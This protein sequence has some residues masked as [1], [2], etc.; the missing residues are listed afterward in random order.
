MRSG[1]GLWAAIAATAAVGWASSVQAEAQGERL[2]ERVVRPALARHCYECHSA[3]ADE[4]KGGLRLDRPQ[5]L[6]RGGDSGKPA[7]VPGKPG[8]SRLI[9]AIRYQHDDLQMPPEEKLPADV[10]ADIEKWVRM[11]APDPR[12]KQQ[13]DG[14]ETESSD[15]SDT[16]AY[17][18]PTLPKVPEVDHEGWARTPIDR[19]ILARLEE[20]GLSPVRDAT[21][22]ALIR[23]ASFDLLGLPPTRDAVERFL[24]DDRPGAFERAVDRMLASPAF[25]ERWGRHWLDVARYAESTGKEWNWAFPHAWRYRD[26][27][28]DAF[29]EDKPYDQ[30]I[31]EQL[32]GDLLPADSDAE[33]SEQRTA[34]GFLAIGPKSVSIG[35]NGKFRMQVADEQIRATSRAFLGLTVGCARCHDHKFDPVTME[36]YYGLAGMFLSTKTLFGTTSKGYK[37]QNNNQARGLVPIG[38]NADERQKAV[39]SHEKKL[40]K[41]GKQLKKKKKALKKAKKKLKKLEDAKQSAGK[42]DKSKKKAK[43]AERARKRVEKLRQK[44]GSLK[45]Q[46]KSLKNNPPKEPKYTMGVRDRGDPGDTKLRKNGVF[47][48]RGKKVA[49]GFPAELTGE[50]PPEVP[51]DRSGRRALAE[52][53]TQPR[54]PVTARV[55]VN[56][57]WHYLFGRGLV[58]TVDN[59]GVLGRKPTHPKLLDYLAV[60][61]AR[62]GWSIKRLIRRIMV[63]RVYRMSTAYQEAGGSADP[64]NRLLWRMRP[65]RLDAESLRD[66][67]LAASGALD[68]R[69]VE[70]SPAVQSLPNGWI[71]KEIHKKKFEKR[72]PERRRSV[73][74]PILRGRVPQVLATFDFPR[75]SLVQGNREVTTVPSQA[76]FMMNSPFVIEQSQ[77]MADR[78][79]RMAPG[80]A[81]KRVSLAYELALVRKPR[82]EER[83]RAVKYVEEISKTLAGKFEDERKRR[84]KAWASFCQTLFASAEFRYLI[85]VTGD[86]ATADP[87][88]VARK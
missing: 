2:F 63:S 80:S 22:R 31:R 28:I 73:Y 14:S 76:L 64:R 13:E 1:I 54:H 59:L 3:E 51:D 79:F 27:V 19:F 21:R 52:W 40:Q 58:R 26:Y 78:L 85:S 37:G 20:A 7:V 46:R 67:M 72:I 55:L 71:E 49:R 32:A 30:F 15:L 6:R 12:R 48:S 60:R 5:G 23:R 66:A 87:G 36:D 45:D 17:K 35:N 25:G 43:Q 57:V 24:E 65:K 41:V 16:W 82:P 4:L 42:K 8:E 44:V 74:F 38:P 50:S 39:E 68:R 69:P 83:R 70:G 81:A 53:L 61:F 47:N 84:R 29:N 11:G 33:R 86:G 77:R 34:T 18:P 75:P 10:I 56:R 9:R 88:R 62:D